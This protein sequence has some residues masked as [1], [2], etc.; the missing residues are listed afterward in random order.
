MRRKQVL[1]FTLPL[2]F[3]IVITATWPAHAD[4]LMPPPGAVV[5]TGRFGPRTEISSTTTPGNTDSLFV[6]SL[7]GS[8]YL[9]QNIIADP[10]YTGNGIEIANGVNDVTLDL[11]GFVIQGVP[12]SG[13]GIH[14]NIFE[15]GARNINITNG[16]VRGWGDDGIEFDPGS[17]DAFVIRLTGIRVMLNS[18]NGI[19]I[20]S[21]GG[22]YLTH[23]MARA[24]GASGFNIGG[25]SEVRQCLVEDNGGDGIICRN[26][27]RIVDNYVNRHCNGAGVHQVDGAG[28]LIQRNRVNE[29]RIKVDSP[30]NVI[31]QNLVQVA[32]EGGCSSGP[33]YE[34]AGGNSFG[35]IVSIHHTGQ[36]G[37]NAWA[38]FED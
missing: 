26:N 22:L 23:C 15:S 32:A 25:A 10:G 28:T 35:E 27:C 21:G 18:G 30:G 33:S 16:T 2:C 7:P 38:N 20:T 14:V 4:N 13:D 5:A 19:T 11:N 1:T 29:G 8:Y 36:I 3:C 24:N 6:I 34:L 37:A 12:G 17:G 31:V 9:P